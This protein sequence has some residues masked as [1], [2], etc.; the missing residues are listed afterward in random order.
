MR[1]KMFDQIFL[2]LLLIEVKNRNSAEL[3]EIKCILVNRLQISYINL[4]GV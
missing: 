2:S 1:F 3:G 4:I